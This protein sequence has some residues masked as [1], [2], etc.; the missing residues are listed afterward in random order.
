MITF[1]L[2]ELICCQS[3]GQI[4]VE[5][6]GSRG[7]SQDSECPLSMPQK[8]QAKVKVLIIETPVRNQNF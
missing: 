4:V 1:R 3:R 2:Y 6:T 8:N 5:E 7:T